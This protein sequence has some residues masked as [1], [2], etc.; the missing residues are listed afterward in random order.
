[1]PQ[2]TILFYDGDCALCNK[3]V[4]FVIDHEKKTEHPMLF[5]SLQSTYAK[6]VLEKHNY[7]FNQLSTLVLLIDSN[8][9]YKSTAAL[10]LSN[11]LKLPYKWLIV[12][13]VV[14]RFVRD[15]VYD[16]IAKN[17]KRLIKRSFCYI[18][19]RELKDRFIG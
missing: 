1:M 6:Q 17:R 7:N 9:L 8:V 3:S 16:F 2:K 4:Q 11:Y 19:S 15:S 10:E 14:P 5:C 18:P 12:L 13:K